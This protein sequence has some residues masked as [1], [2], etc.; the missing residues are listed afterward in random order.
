MSVFC[1]CEVFKEG[2]VLFLKQWEKDDVTNGGGSGEHHDQ[3]VNTDADTTCGGHAVFE[4]FD[5]VV[6]NLL[7]L[8]RRRLGALGVRAGGRGR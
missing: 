2:L 3:A 1:K 4:G 5:E 7:V 8:P 6:V